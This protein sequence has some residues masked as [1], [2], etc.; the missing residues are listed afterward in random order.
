L[1]VQINAGKRRDAIGLNNPFGNSEFSQIQTEASQFI[2]GFGIKDAVMKGIHATTEG[3]NRSME[4]NRVQLEY[5]LRLLFTQSILLQEELKT[6][7][8]AVVWT[9]NEYQVTQSSFKAGVA[10]KLTLYRTEQEHNR[11]KSRKLQR[12]RQLYSLHQQLQA[13][14]GER[15]SAQ[16]SLTTLESKNIFNLS[17]SNDSK[18]LEVSLLR[19]AIELSRQTTR[20]YRLSHRPE[21]HG[22]VSS[23]QG[24]DQWHGGQTDHDWRAGLQLK[25]TIDSSLRLKQLS[26]AQEL[27]TLSLEEDLKTLIEQRSSLRE[28]LILSEQQIQKEI[29]ILKDT[30]TQAQTSYEITLSM[31]KN[32]TI[33]HPRLEETRYLLS[34]S[35]LDL[36]QAHYEYQRLVHESWRWKQ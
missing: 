32:G 22:F 2:Y 16:G 20:G 23:Q 30:V 29:S 26:Q 10:S 13:I 33:T 21:L 35:Q 19:H 3:A 31:Y 17:P 14:L 8:A 11:A 18:G 7:S 5:Q 12:E 36:S 6:L 9:K 34:Q 28:Y 25:W 1:N 24:G 15:I 4:W 27:Q